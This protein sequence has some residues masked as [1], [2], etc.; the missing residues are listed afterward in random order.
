MKRLTWY[1]SVILLCSNTIK[2]D[3]E[4][5]RRYL[6]PQGN[7]IHQLQSVQKPMTETIAIHARENA[8]SDTL[9][10]RK[11]ILVRYPNAK[12]TVVISHGFMCD[13][14]DAGFIRQLF[15]KGQYNF[16]TF[17]MRA[18]G[19]N[20]EGQLCTFGKNEAYDVIAAA[21]YIK[22]HPELKKLPVFGYGFSMGAV[23][24]IE[25]QAKE[26]GLFSALILD[27]PFDST[28][29]VIKKMLQSFKFSIFGYE[30]E[31]PGLK[32]LEQYAF[33]PYVQAFI[34]LLLKT[35]PHMDAKNIQTY[36]HRFSPVES[37]KKIK[38]PCLFI[39]C[40]NDSRITVEA[41]QSIFKGAQGPKILWLT[42]GR[43]HYDSL[44]YNPEKYAKKI[45]S[46]YENVLNGKIYQKTIKV[47]QDENPT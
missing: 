25:A 27:C 3:S 46:F 7:Y 30:F 19:E 40:K 1:F 4:A 28:E 41:I 26:P 10:M 5:L 35:V 37:V 21:N 15:P 14:F 9:I 20:K 29:N 6:Y 44:F 17:D 13:K 24:T 22:N 45:G 8:D 23:A 16:V 43:G 2:P 34:K 36:M 42:N 11:G 33:H 38:V 32:F 39:H 31:L 18:H 47:K 12:A